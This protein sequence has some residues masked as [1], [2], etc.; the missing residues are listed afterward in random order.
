MPWSGTGDDGRPREYFI[1][2]AT[3]AMLRNLYRFLRRRD[4]AGYHRCE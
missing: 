3:A 2:G 4:G 1:W